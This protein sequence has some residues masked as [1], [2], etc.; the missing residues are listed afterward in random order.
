MSAALLELEGVNARHSPRAE[1]VLHA[2][3]LRVEPGQTWV[4]LGPNGAGKSTL[5]RAVL[6]LVHVTGRVSVC[7]A[8]LDTLDARELA[9]R[10]AWVPQSIDEQSAFTALDVALMGRA[11]HGSVW[12]MPDD[13]TVTRT[14]ALLEELDIAHL[15]HRPVNELSGG[16]RR[17]VWLARALV[18]DPKVLLLDEPTAFLDIRHQLESMQVVKR[19]GEQGLGVLAVLHD[20]NLARTFATHALLLKDGRTLAQGEVREVLTVARLSE[21]FGV[22]MV[23]AMT[24][25]G[26]VFVPGVLSP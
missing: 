2:L 12:S 13:A 6:G 11:P 17:R 21:L 19:R 18:Q 24:A 8:P 7:G 4:V 14:H 20:V 23:E 16:E 22:P 25:G 9:R 5:V 3:S 15:A 26:G 1:P 10:V